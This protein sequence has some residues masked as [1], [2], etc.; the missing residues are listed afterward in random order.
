[1]HAE[2]DCLAGLNFSYTIGNYIY[3]HRKGGMLAKPCPKCQHVLEQFGFKK[4][5]WA[6]GK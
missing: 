1:V 2:V 4:I 3:I 5:F 6:K